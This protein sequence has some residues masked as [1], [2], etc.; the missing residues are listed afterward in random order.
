MKK[1]V[2]IL[3]FVLIFYAVYSA[4]M[5]GYAYVTI[6]NLV[7]ETV[8]RFIPATPTS[9]DQFATQERDDR[10]RSAVAQ[11]VTAAGMAIEPT[12]VDVAE[13]GGRLA[14][15]VS[16]RYPVVTFQGETKA[17]IPVS[18]TSNFPMGVR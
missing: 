7:D 3:V 15:R 14:V 6:S 1:I 9:G 11:V 2:V 4:G 5:A 12:A 18:V 8:P 10:I 13:E 17:A 16:Y